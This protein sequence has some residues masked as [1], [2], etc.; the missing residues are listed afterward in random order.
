MFKKLFITTT[1]AVLIGVGLTACSTPEAST[2]EPAPAP[3]V[4]EEKETPSAPAEE[5]IDF[6]E[7]SEPVFDGVPVVCGADDVGSE[8][9]SAR[10]R[11]V[12]STHAD[13]VEGD[14]VSFVV[15]CAYPANDEVM[16]AIEEL[17]KAN[18]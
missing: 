11:V 9:S 4:V 1:A 18:G 16:A 14:T 12:D 10:V 13:A 5:F 8:A 7:T 6:A 3:V 17:N 15:E 2:P